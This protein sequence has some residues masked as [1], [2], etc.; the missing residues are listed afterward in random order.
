MRMGSRCDRL[1]LL[2]ATDMIYSVSHA[3]EVRGA[4]L[5]PLRGGNAFPLC[6][7]VE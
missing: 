4:E 1:I 3:G 7:S 6:I 2:L 5:P